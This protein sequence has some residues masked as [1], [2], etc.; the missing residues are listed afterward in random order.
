MRLRKN[1]SGLTP[2]RTSCAQD[3]WSIATFCA[4]PLRRC[5]CALAFVIVMLLRYATESLVFL[6]HN[7]D[8]SARVSCKCLRRLRAPRQY[9]GMVC[10][11]V[12][13]CKRRRMLVHMERDMVLY[14]R[15]FARTAEPIHYRRLATSAVWWS[16]TTW[17]QCPGYICCC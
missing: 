8:E 11:F 10:E 7:V 2:R 17:P 3:K 9:V 13:W 16:D 1:E 15:V 6:V 14:S 12:Y 5:L 4:G